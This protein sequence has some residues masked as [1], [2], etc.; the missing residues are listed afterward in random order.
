MN[1]SIWYVPLVI[2]FKVKGHALSPSP[3]HLRICISS[4][5]PRERSLHTEKYVLCVYVYVYVFER[6]EE[7]WEWRLSTVLNGDYYAHTILLSLLPIDLVYAN[8]Y[9]HASHNNSLH[10]V[11]AINVFLRQNALGCWV[12]GLENQE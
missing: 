2:N 3:V 5:T 12:P 8:P 6:K 1:N 4:V 10:S 7:G 11:H 9:F